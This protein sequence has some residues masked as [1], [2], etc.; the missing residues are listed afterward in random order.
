MTSTP[1]AEHRAHWQRWRV[2]LDRVTSNPHYR[3]EDPQKWL[4]IKLARF[5]AEMMGHHNRLLWHVNGTG[6]SYGV[7]YTRKGY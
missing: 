3:Y 4:L 1:N 2:V 6:T 7:R 5:A